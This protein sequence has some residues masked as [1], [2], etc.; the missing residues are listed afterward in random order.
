MR[1]SDKRFPAV[2][3]EKKSGKA[4]S[5]DFDGRG[6]WAGC[7]FGFMFMVG[8]KHRGLDNGC[9]T[10]EK[11]KNIFERRNWARQE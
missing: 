4:G 1:K 8:L 2:S 3:G 5:D 7:R 11:K 6:T 10:F 9:P